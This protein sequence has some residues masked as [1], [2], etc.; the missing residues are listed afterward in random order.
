MVRIKKDREIEFFPQASHQ[1]GNLTYS[2]E[3]ALA[4]GC[5]NEDRNLKFPRRGEYCLQQN[6][7]RDIKMTERHSIFLY[8]L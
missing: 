4:L 8:K 5:S 7:I 2:H 1:S 3:L 6:Q